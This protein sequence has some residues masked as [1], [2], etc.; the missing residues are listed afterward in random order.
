MLLE[1][2]REHDLD[3]WSPKLLA[4]KDVAFEIAVTS[5]EGMNHPQIAHNGDVI[6]IEDPVVGPIRQVGP[7]AHFSTSPMT[8]S[9]SAPALGAAGDEPFAD[10][11]IVQREGEAPSAPFAGV[12][13][14]E[15]G[16]FYAMP[17]AV[18]MLASLGARVIKLEDGNGDPHR[19]SFGPD[20]ATNKTTAGKESISINLK[21]PEG[22]AVAQRICAEADVFITGFRSGIP[23]K[24]GLGHEQLRELN[25]RLV[26]VHA[27]GYGVDGPFAHRA[28]YAQAAQ[29]VGGSFGRQ[30]GYWS[31]PERNTDM[32]LI[33]LQAIVIPRLGQVVDGDS[34]PA[35]AVLATLGPGHLSPAPYGRRAVHPHVDDRGERLGLLRRLLHLRREATRG[36]S[37]TRT[38]GASVPS[39]ASTPRRMTPTCA[40]PSMRTTSSS[41]SPRRSA[42]R[43]SRAIR[44][45]ARWRLGPSTTNR[46]SRPSRR[47]CSNG[48]PPSGSSR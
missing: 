29:S 33:E 15:F 27:A 47:A 19:Q 1:A 3:Y 6:T 45:S 46:W 7:I 21:T 17:Y 28:L 12:T 37:A 8:P 16:Y 14:V 41:P 39:T 44:A 48:R 4:S 43:S 5:E 42:S 30:V 38:T 25:P 2:F 34:N 32:S 9:R 24:F 10:V 35:L 18:T 13:I 31:E 23:E 26:Y 20:V 36:R 11:A 22:Q 40:S